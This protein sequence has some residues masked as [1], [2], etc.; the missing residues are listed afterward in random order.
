M[1]LQ[2]SYTGT[3]QKNKYT[4]AYYC[5]N[6]SCTLQNKKKSEIQGVS[7]FMNNVLAIVK[8]VFYSHYCIN[9]LFNAPVDVRIKKKKRK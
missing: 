1:G 7:D 3:E 9:M 8:D 2:G 6:L 4:F 5:L